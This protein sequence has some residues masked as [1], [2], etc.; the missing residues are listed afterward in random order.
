[1]ETRPS[2]FTVRLGKTSVSD[3]KR[4]DALQPGVQRQPLELAVVCKQVPRT[5]SAGSYALIWLG[6]DNSKGT[7]TAW[8]QGFR[9]IARIEDVDMG[10]GRNDDSTTRL[11]IGFVLKESLTKP[12]LL[13][14]APAAYARY[15]EMVLFGMDDYANQ[16]IRAVERSTKSDIGALFLS[17][18]IAQPGSFSGIV[19][20]YPVL[21]PI[22][23]KEEELRGGTGTAPHKTKTETL[24]D[25]QLS[26]NM[27]VH[28]APGTG[29]SYYIEELRNLYFDE[30]KVTRVTFYPNYSYSQFVGGYKPRSGLNGRGEHEVYYEFVLG[31][32]LETYVDALK[33]PED[34]YL[35]IVEEINRANSAAVFGD[36]FQ[37]LDRNLAGV[38]EYPIR[39][40]R[41][42]GEELYSRLHHTYYY[43]TPYAGFT[44]GESEN[45]RVGWMA[46]PSNMFIWATMNSADQGVFPIDTAFRRRWDFMYLSIDNA[47]EA[48]D[49]NVSLA[50]GHDISWNALR[51]ALNDKLLTLGIDEDKLLGPFFIGNRDCMLQIQADNRFNAVFKDKVI[52]YLFNDVV[53]H[54]RPQFF[55]GASNPASYSQVCADFDLLGERVFGNYDLAI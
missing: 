43:E 15:S 3:I 52:T 8:K 16:T 41:E 19:E 38:S 37:L 24:D 5:L 34:R 44:A 29:K 32:F 42:M 21:A 6:S 27:I 40:S 22:I 55:S 14:A 25:A 47:R 51:T 49:V 30:D 10:A 53:R 45:E 7:P 20:A 2:F 39:I 11:S 13:V 48:A 17:C 18:D 33:H 1:M 23:A 35:L 46:L 28:G 26:R 4:I 54:C 12:D 50:A 36:V 31:P 9:A